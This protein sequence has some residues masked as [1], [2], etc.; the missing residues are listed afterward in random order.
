MGLPHG[1]CAYRRGE[2]GKWSAGSAR[3]AQELAWDFFGVNDR[4]LRAHIGKARAGAPHEA[5]IVRAG[6]PLHRKTA[7]VVHL[8][9]VGLPRLAISARLK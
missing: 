6:Q 4:R 9:S 2:P 1:D 8:T 5:F 3:L 7:I